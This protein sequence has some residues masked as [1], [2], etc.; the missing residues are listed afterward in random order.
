M[1]DLQQPVSTLKAS[2]FTLTAIEQP[3]STDS[4]SGKAFLDML[5][6]FTE[7]ELNIRR[8]R[9]MEGIAAAKKTGKYKGRKPVSVEVKGQIKSLNEQHCSVTSIAKHTGVSRNTV[10]KV[11]K[12][13]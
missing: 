13:E 5:A 10:Y 1:L 8:E 12:S 2:G 4:A 3:V 7:F 6:V 9:Q 11:L